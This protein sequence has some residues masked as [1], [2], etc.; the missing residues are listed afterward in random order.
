MSVRRGDPCTIEGCDKPVVGRGWCSK[1]YAVWRKFGDP[2]HPTRRY[3][4]QS[5]SCSHEGCVRKPKRRGLCEM[6][7]KRDEK[8]GETTDPRKRNFWLQVNKDGPIPP[9][10][11]D[12]G[13]CWEWTGYIQPKTGY[14]QFGV[15][16]GTRLA[17]RVAYQFLVGPIPAGMH[18]DHLCRNR[19]CV[20]AA[21]HLDPVPPREN[22][23]RGIQGAFWGYVPDPIPLKP[24]V[25]KP[26]ACT[27]EGCDRP[28][29]KRTICRPCYKKWLRDP[30]VVRPR[31]L[32]PE[33]RFWA[34]VDKEGPVPVHRPELGPCWVWTAHVNKGVGYGQFS[35]KHGVQVGAHRFAYELTNGPIADGYE[36]HHRCHTRRCVRPEHLAA[37]TRSENMAERK[38]RR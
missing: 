38:V 1:H 2:L 34:K 13:P 15:R 8:H 30:T 6:H 16:S 18:L 29:Y 3:E 21:G 33:Q 31:S 26:T 12:L 14:G 22:L 20:N 28:V 35:P 23:R 19:R 25:E 9:D 17:H 32:T 11:P 37:A 4:R 27:N 36:V 10:R 7:A 24:K 5:D